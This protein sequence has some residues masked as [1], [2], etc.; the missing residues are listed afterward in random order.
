MNPILLRTEKQP[1]RLLP[2]PQKSNKPHR[3]RAIPEYPASSQDSITQNQ[4]GRY[5]TT[6]NRYNNLANKNQ[7]PVHTLH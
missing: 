4:G 6:P 7:K 2:K 5:N 1:R 3:S